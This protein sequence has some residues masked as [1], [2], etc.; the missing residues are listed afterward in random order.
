[1]AQYHHITCEA[2]QGEG[3]HYAGDPNDPWPR[4]LGPCE[5]CEGRGFNMRSVDDE[6]DEDAE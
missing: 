5:E 4:D 3:R 2:C 6:G 1:M